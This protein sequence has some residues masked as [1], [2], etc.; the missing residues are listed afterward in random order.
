[1]QNKQKFITDI[2]AS[3]RYGYSRAWFQRSRWMGD[4]PP[5]LKIKNGRVL[6][7]IDSTDQW[8]ENHGLRFSTS[9]N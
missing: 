7:P 1:M 6:Y 2:E 8:F 9:Q 5:F 4:G 3:A